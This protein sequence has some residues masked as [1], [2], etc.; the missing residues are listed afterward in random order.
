MHDSLQFYS[1]FL[2]NTL[3]TWL[4]QADSDKNDGYALIGAYA[5]V[6]LGL[7]VRQLFLIRS[8]VLADSMPDSYLPAVMP[9]KCRRL[10]L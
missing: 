8:S 9:S 7:A 6:F 4:E 1:V 2:I 10:L 3:L 5:L